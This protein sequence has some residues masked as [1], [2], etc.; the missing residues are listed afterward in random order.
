MREYDLKQLIDNQSHRISKIIDFQER[1][2]LNKQA[3]DWQEV[4]GH[5]QKSRHNLRF[6][7]ENIKLKF[8]DWAITG[9]Y[10]ACYHAAIALIQTRGYSSKNHLATLC[11]LIQEFY[12]NGLTKEDIELLSNF[13][14]YK[15]ILFY[16]Q[17]KNKREEAT[18]STKLLFN[19]QEAQDLRFKAIMFVN[20]VEE[21]IK[22][23]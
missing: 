16:V 9:C 13:L 23:A 12:N 5:L 1:K 18:Y 11:I 14:D 20:R 7:Q 15:D 6:I 8:F 3:A 21:I 17:S 4:E 2:I 10:Y 19:K 22:K